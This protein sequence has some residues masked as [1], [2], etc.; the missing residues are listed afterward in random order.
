MAEIRFQLLKNAD[1]TPALETL[2][3][4]GLAF[5]GATA[6]SSVQIGAYQ[7]VT[8]VSNPSGSSYEDETNN[9]KYVASR[10]PSGQCDIAG[11]FGTEVEVGLSG[12]KTMQGTLGIEFG[13]TAAVN[14]QNVQ[15]RVYDRGSVNYPASG[16]NTKVAEIINYDANTWDNQG[17]TGSTSDAVGSGDAFW[18]GEAWPAA[19]VSKNYYTNSSAVV[20][21]NG[22]DADARVNGDARLATAAV[23]ASYDTVGGTGIVVPLMDSPGSGGKQL[24]ATEVISGTGMVWPKWSQYIT[25]TSNQQL[26]FGG[27]TSY[28]FGDGSDT[29]KVNNLAPIDQTYGG[30]GVD[31]HHTWSIGLSASPLS[32]GSKEEYGLYVSLEYL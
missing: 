10:F 26:Y 16:V 6:G 12:V 17:A 31:T 29:V 2:S 9:I 1:G 30:S 13:H 7:G 24:Q 32:T 28:N 8:R 21:Y 5:Y 19:L 20:F 4:S 3:G 27:S 14:V 18:W 15:L 11:S 25:T 23:A 22:T